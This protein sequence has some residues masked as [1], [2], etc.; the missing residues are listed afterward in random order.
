MAKSEHLTAPAGTGAQ[1]LDRVVARLHALHS[2]WPAHDGVAV[3]NRVYLSVTE[4]IRRQVDAGRFRD[5]HTAVTLDALF[6]ERYLS[7]ALAASAGDRVPA[8]WRPPFRRR[9]HPGVLPLQF[10]TAGINAHIGHDLALAVVDTCH[11]LGCAP[12]D[13]EHEFDQVGEVLELLETRVREEV[14]PGP[15][16]LELADPLTHLLGCWSLGQARRAAWSSALVLWGLR[17]VPALAEEFRVRLDA[18]VGLVSR[19]LLTPCG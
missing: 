8:C 17:E 10:A 5:P 13:L 9:R 15:D 2:A 18:G 3:F 16:P 4:E 14:M 19:C 12:K 6:A 11:A 7:A 1:P